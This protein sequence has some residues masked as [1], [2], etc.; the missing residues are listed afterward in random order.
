LPP[1]LDEHRSIERFHGT[2]RPELGDLG[3]FESL[4]AA[5]AAVDACVG[6]YNQDRPHQGLNATVPVVPADRSPLDQ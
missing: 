2:L 3:P 5:Q 1:R 6:A 4:A